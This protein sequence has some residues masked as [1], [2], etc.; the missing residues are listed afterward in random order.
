MKLIVISDEERIFDGESSRVDINTP[1]G[2]ATILP[3]HQPYLTK[4]YGALTYMCADTGAVMIDARE[5]FLYTNGE[6]C[7][8]VLDT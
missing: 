6:T 7:F 5:G 8:V 2:P 1:N 3:M 4:I